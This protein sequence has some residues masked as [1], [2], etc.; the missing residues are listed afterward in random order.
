VDRSLPFYFKVLFL[1]GATVLFVSLCV[2]WYVFQMF[3]NGIV[4]VS[5]SYNIFFEWSTDLPSGITVNENFRPENLE[6]SPIL[7]FIFI[8][9][10]LFTIYTIFFQDLEQSEDVASLRKFSFGFV[11]LIGLLLFYIVIFPSM[12]LIPHELYFPSLIDN[13]LDLG[14][15]ISYAISYGYILQLIGFIL[16]FPYSL[17]YYLATTQFER[18]ENT[19]E[20]KIAS[21]IKNI[22]ERIDLDKY[23]AEEEALS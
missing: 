9:V 19:P 21:Y 7:N 23:I 18:Q 11:C 13:N 8:G 14:V 4:T 5:W 15:R 17:H 3:E 1:A 20:K 16:V 22:Q 2:E 6:L 12:Y 10:L